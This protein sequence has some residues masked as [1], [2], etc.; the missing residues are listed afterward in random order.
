LKID[1]TTGMYRFEVEPGE[2]GAAAVQQPQ[3]PR[4]TGPALSSNAAET[5][6]GRTCPPGKQCL[7]FFPNDAKERAKEILKK[8]QPNPAAQDAW[9]PS[10]SGSSVIRGN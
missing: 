2:A 4:T 1:L 3:A 6:T 7:L 9:Q 10:T 8:A 5:P